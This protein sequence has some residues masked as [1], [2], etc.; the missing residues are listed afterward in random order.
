GGE[1]VK[2]VAVSGSPRM[3]SVTESFLNCFL[4]GLGPDVSITR[5]Y[6]YRMN[7]KFCQACWHCWLKTPGKCMLDD[8]MADALLALDD[9]DLVVLASPVYVDGFPGAVKAFIDR[10]IP[11]IEPAI[12]VDAEGHSRHR[13]RRA[14]H[15]TAVLIATCGFPEVDNFDAMRFHFMAIC[16]NAGWDYGGE[17][18]ISQSGIA[19]VPGVFDEKYL[20]ATKAGQECR[21]GRISGETIDLISRPILEHET[22]RQVVN[23]S[24]E[25]GFRG[26]ASE[27][28][29]KA[30]NGNKKDLV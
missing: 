7:L 22:Y 14:K 21:L 3:K 23:A 18:V 11:L 6:P 19:R 13:R 25:G 12:T 4:E 16:R 1:T 27:L 20:L 26:Q 17:L 10:I 9:A 5:F 15:Q 30:L 24:F 8:D 2:V 28:L 29:R